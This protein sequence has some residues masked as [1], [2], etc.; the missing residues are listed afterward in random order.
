MSETPVTT[1]EVI[2]VLPETEEFTTE[3]PIYTTESS[4]ILF[5]EITTPLAI[6]ISTASTKEM[7]EAATEYYIAR[8]PQYEEYEDYEKEIPIYSRNALPATQIIL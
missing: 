2:S 3:S 1:L 4:T 6:S 5:T 7:P 8:G